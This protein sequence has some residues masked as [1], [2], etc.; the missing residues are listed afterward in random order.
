MENNLEY[1]FKEIL[2]QNK[3]IINILRIIRSVD[4]KLV[5]SAGTIRNNIWQ[6]LENNPQ[7]ITSDVDII[8]YDKNVSEKETKKIEKSL[9]KINSNYKWQVKNEY[10]MN[11]YDFPN[12]PKFKS[13]SESI[14]H[15]VE[16]PTCIAAYL[17]NNNN[18]QIIAPYGL[19][20]LMVLECRPIPLLLNK[21]E[22][23]NIYNNRILNK[24]W[25]K[26]YPNL[27]IYFS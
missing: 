19:K 10:Y 3:D 4:K 17:D 6:Y 21:P 26:A 9:Y 23:M 1:K 22:K 12:E 14:S 15:F 18:I 25:K 13:L 16:T 5:L 2:K 7:Y 20:D 11:Q 27:D 8:Y 24:K